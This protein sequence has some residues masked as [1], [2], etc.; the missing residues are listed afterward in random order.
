MQ[1]Y[2]KHFGHHQKYREKGTKHPNSASRTISTRGSSFES[3][4]IRD[5]HM[6]NNSSLD[7]STDH[8]RDFKICKLDH[9]AFVADHHPNRSGNVNVHID[10]LMEA[11]TETI[12]QLSALS[13]DDEENDTLDHTSTHTT[14]TA[15][16]HTAHTSHRYDQITPGGSVESSLKSP[17]VSPSPHSRYHVRRKRRREDFPESMSNSVHL[18]LR[19]M[20]LKEA[21]VHGPAPSPPPSSPQLTP[22]WNVSS[23]AISSDPSLSMISMSE[24]TVT[25]ASQSVTCTTDTLS[26]PPSDPS[27]SISMLSEDPKLKRIGDGKM[28]PQLR[29]QRSEHYAKIERL[30]RAMYHQKVKKMKRSNQ[31]QKSNKSNLSIISMSSKST[32]KQQMNRRMA[33][34]SVD[35]ARSRESR[36]SP[37]D[38]VVLPMLRLQRTFSDETVSVRTPSISE[39]SIGPPPYF[40]KR[41]LASSR[42]LTQKRSLNR[43]L[44]HH[45]NLNHDPIEGSPSPESIS[46]TPSPRQIHYSKRQM[47][48]ERNRDMNRDLSPGQ[49]RRAK[50]KNPFKGRRGSKRKHI[51]KVPLIRESYVH[52][53]P[54]PSSSKGRRSSRGKRMSQRGARDMHYHIVDSDHGSISYV[55]FNEDA[56]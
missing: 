13:D 37:H 8:Q 29:N 32:K 43:F 45:H 38:S 20:R 11:H 52:S 25:T 33:P 24:P 40:V 46:R 16:T 22:R 39:G 27:T 12:S 47:N 35:S 5:D 42:V 15:S 9:Y 34:V 30:E 53:A 4:E 36:P 28:T 50:K 26:L 7:S 3:S 1:Y 49:I 23:S 44:D 17:V 48:R 21:D 14:H 18:E 56:L 31:S 41:D 19:S 54:F 2:Q 51:S 10:N 6:I 55:D